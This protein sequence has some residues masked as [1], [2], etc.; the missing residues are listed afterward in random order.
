[1]P[2]AAR[3]LYLNNLNKKKKKGKLNR[4]YL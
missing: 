3:Q 1:M 2:A 4:L